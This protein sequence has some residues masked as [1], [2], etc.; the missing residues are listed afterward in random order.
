MTYDIYF[1]NDFDGRACAAVMLS[2][3]RSR[4]DDIQRFVAM[5]YGKEQAWYEEDF[6]EKSG[7][8][9]A[10]VV[11]FTY[12]P[13]AAWW[14][15]HHPST[16]KKPEW[17]S[18]FTPDKQ[19]HLES[20]YPSCCG[21]VYDALQRDFGWKP[22]RHFKQFVTS[23]NMIDGAKYRSAKQ[24]IEAKTPDLKMNAFIEALPHSAKENQ[25]MIELMSTQSL[26]NVIK[27]PVINTAIRKLE[28]NVAKSLAFQKKNIETFGNV[29]F[30]NLANDPLNGL[31]RYASYYLYPKS[32]FGIRM[33]PKGKLWYLGVGVNPWRKPKLDI[34]LGALMRENYHGGGHYGIGA[35]EFHSKKEAMNA[36]EEIIWRLNRD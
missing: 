29:T 19:H 21:L 30:I 3:L 23:A 36:K 7:K 10:I 11:D 22:P 31:L 1:H 14:F 6:F 28:K 4:G 35:T 9:P 20:D 27:H 17:K 15:D 2:F 26:A 34:D 12:H 33:R 25:L 32:E 18:R 5:T 13:K 16:F 24:T 8:N